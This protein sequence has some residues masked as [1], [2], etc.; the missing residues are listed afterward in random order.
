VLHLEAVDSMGMGVPI[1]EHEVLRT[2]KEV[3]HRRAK[4]WVS[5]HKENRSNVT[6]QFCQEHG[7]SRWRS[8]V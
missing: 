8:M 2:D 4:L 1:R 6:G 3:G 7:F 5:I